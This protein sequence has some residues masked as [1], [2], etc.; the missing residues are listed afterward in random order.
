MKMLDELGYAG[1]QVKKTDKNLSIAFAVVAALVRG[2]KLV[3]SRRLR[4]EGWGE[5][6]LSE[7]RR[8]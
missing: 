5:Y 3:V 7:K 6:V 4:N 8:W 2:E 1:L